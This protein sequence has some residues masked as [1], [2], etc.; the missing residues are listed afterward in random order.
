MDL[1]GETVGHIRIRSLIGEGGMVAEGWSDPEMLE[2]CRE[3]GL[4]IPRR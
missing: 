3:H 1:I 2:L 4:R